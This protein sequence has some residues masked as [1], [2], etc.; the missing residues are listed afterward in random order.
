MHKPPPRLYWDACAW[1]AYINKEMPADGNAI[2]SRRFEMC[3]N[4]LKRAEAGDVEIVTSAFT[5]AEV[6]K[7]QPDPASPAVNLAAFFDQKYI[8][9][10]PV[11]KQIALRAQ[12]LQLAGIAGVKPAD[13]VHLASALVAN[14]PVFHTFDKKLLGLDKKLNLADGSA[15]SIV[16]PTEEVPMPELLKAMQPDKTGTNDPALKPN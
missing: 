5:L 1:I 10:I 12:N 6:C 16:R 4:T 3:Q 13:A 7:R 14:I 8:L 9:L 11:D 15:L 2:T